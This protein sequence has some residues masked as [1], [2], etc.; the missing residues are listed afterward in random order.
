MNV[1]CI[2]LLGHQ[3]YRITLL[4]NDALPLHQHQNWRT[5]SALLH[6]ILRWL[7]HISL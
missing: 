5:E 4:I 2:C 3:Y 7:L 1:Y 6:A